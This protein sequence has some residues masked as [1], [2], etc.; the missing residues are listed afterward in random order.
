MQ[1][2]LFFKCI[3]HISLLSFFVA[4]SFNGTLAQ[5]TPQSTPEK[6]DENETQAS[7]QGLTEAI[8]IDGEPALRILNRKSGSTEIRLQKR[9]NEDALVFSVTRLTSFGLGVKPGDEGKLYVTKNRINYSPN[10]E[11]EQ[12]FSISS[13]DIQNLEL[14]KVGQGFE[15]I[16][17]TVQ[18][19]KK[20][21]IFSGTVYIDGTIS[22][23][24]RIN[25]KD[26][27]P[28]L[29]FLFRA[30]KNFDAAL[31]EFNQLTANV[32]PT[33]DDDEA[34]TEAETEAEISDKYDRFRDITVIQTPR[35]LVRGNKRSIRTHAEYSFTGKKQIKPEKVSLY[36][37]ASAARPLFREDELELNFLVDQKRVALGEMR[38]AD[39]E[40]T[41]T[42][43][44]QTVVIIVPFETFVQIAN[45][46][47]VE[48]QIGTNEFKLTGMHL[49]AFKKLPAYKVDETDDK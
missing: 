4:A 8:L 18:N 47:K 30:L 17:F 9:D 40:K 36:F 29:E 49:E 26:L 25:K 48:F 6:D 41:K 1:I 33:S 32:R 28:S 27:R 23:G 7:L 5:T 35:M 42:T 21:F 13:S 11:K 38:L 16:S 12:F 3:F 31:T 45:A 10:F 34:E 22:G 24:L 19:D 14:K 15:A 39:E 2:N 37:H 46:K 43:V 20:R 44:R